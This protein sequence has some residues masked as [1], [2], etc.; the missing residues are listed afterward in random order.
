MEDKEEKKGIEAPEDMV[1]VDPHMPLYS[2]QHLCIYL[3]E[4]YD[5]AEAEAE[6]KANENKSIS[7][8]K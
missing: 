1:V 3:R 6:T 2:R 8:D 4:L 5:M 7:E